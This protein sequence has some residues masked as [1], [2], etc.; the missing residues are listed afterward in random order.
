MASTNRFQA[1]SDISHFDDPEEDVIMGPDA[2]SGEK[3]LVAGRE[4]NL[5]GDVVDEEEE[6]DDRAYIDEEDR[7]RKVSQGP[8]EIQSTFA[9]Q[10]PQVV[11]RTPGRG[12][13]GGT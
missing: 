2:D 11:A 6:E 12:R 7:R 5:Q 4:D 10:S 1:L 8:R 13:G 9:F 3:A